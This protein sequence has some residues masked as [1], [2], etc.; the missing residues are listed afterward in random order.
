MDSGTWSPI[1]FRTR[2][3]S[4]L[5]K[6]RESAVALGV[7][8]FEAVQ[9]ELLLDC[10]VD[11]VGAAVRERN[12]AADRLG[13]PSGEQFCRVVIGADCHTDNP[14]RMVTDQQVDRNPVIRLTGKCCNS[15]FT[16]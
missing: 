12:G 16:G 13:D 7:G 1:S 15:A 10:W 8:Y 3:V 14:G 6:Q 2:R 4:R 5:D 11:H 9:V